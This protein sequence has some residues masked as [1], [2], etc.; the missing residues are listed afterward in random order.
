MKCLHCVGQSVGFVTLTLLWLVCAIALSATAALANDIYVNDTADDTTPGDGHCTLREAVNNANANFDLTGG[1]CMRGA[2][3][4]ADVI[5][6]PA[7]IY[8]LTTG[9]ENGNASGDLDVF[10]YGG[11]LTFQ[12]AG[13]QNS[14]ITGPGYV[15]GTDRLIELNPGTAAAINVTVRDLTLLRGYT[16]GGGGAI[17]NNGATLLVEDC[18]IDENGAFFGRSG[19]KGQGGA[20]Y[21]QGGLV[22][23]RRTALRHNT[24]STGVIYIAG[25]GAI[26]NTG[27]GNVVIEDS[28][29]VANTARG[30][31]GTGGQVSG[32]AIWNNGGAVSLLRTQVISNSATGG[33]SGSIGNGGALYNDAQSYTWISQCVVAENRAD[34]SGGAVYAV[35][36]IGIIDTLLRQNVAGDSGGALALMSGIGS[37]ERTTFSENAADYG[38]GIIIHGSVIL[39]NATLFGNLTT[40]S[41]GGVYV[42]LGG[43]LHTNNATLQANR[44]DTDQDGN[45]GGGGIYTIGI[46]AVLHNTIVAGNFDASP[47]GV[48]HADLLGDFVSQGYNLIGDIT[49]ATGFISGANHDI[50]GTFN[51]PVAALLLPLGWYG[52]LTPTC[53]P[54]PGSPAID[55]GDPSYYATTDQRG[56]PRPQGSGVDI[57]AVEICK[58]HLPLVLRI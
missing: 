34:G 54:M 33:V 39:S 38:G 45:G 19:N 22:T 1:D 47:A 8:Q 43:E 41:G 30:I 24:A 52:G 11:D 15:V 23:V 36:D 46:Q 21:N 29:L 44:A 56:V 5:H 28:E 49:G 9:V 12:G 17:Y 25:G 10:A 7:G 2:V 26:Y 32:G 57:G 50:L 3:V 13:Q 42:F 6:L 4:P 20:L 31:P 53:L 55:N 48:N 40:D 58:L 14:I 18:T 27:G 16:P 35:A 51:S 37:V